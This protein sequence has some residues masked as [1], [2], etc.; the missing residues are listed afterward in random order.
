[1]RQE[2][3][4]ARTHEH[5]PGLPRGRASLPAGAVRAAQRERLVRA[6]IAASSEHGYLRVTVADVV[7]R[8]KVSR[9]AFYAHFTDK[10]DC[11]LA[12]AL[13]GRRLLIG[14][15]TAETGALP[16]DTPPEDT[17]RVACRAFLR[18]L[19]DEPEFA[20]VFYLELPSGGPRAISRTVEAQRAY[21]HLNQLWHQRARAHDPTVPAVPDEAF[22][23]AVG[24]TTELVRAAVHDGHPPLSELED[25]LV[26]LHLAILAGKSWASPPAAR[27]KTR[28]QAH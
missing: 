5:E 1:M 9:A 24:A 6:I 4:L 25:V 27:P 26:G 11:L 14:H 28:R 13:F 22:V 21:A 17:L 23:A 7:Q 8:A 12:A 19:T 20:R 18:F 16:K 3:S 2:G 10:D 15:I